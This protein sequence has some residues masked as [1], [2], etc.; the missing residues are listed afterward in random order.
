MASANQEWRRTTRILENLPDAVVACTRDGQILFVNALAEE[1]FGYSRDELV[2]QPVQMLW[3]ERV[4]D[5]YSHN[6]IVFFGSDEALRFSTEVWGLRRDGSEFAGE[7]SWGV[8]DTIAGRVLLAIGR[9][10]SRRLTAE[11]RLRAVAAINERALGGA[12]LSDLAIE[13][14]ELLRATLPL[15]GAEVRL[16]DGGVLASQGDVTGAQ[17]APGDRRR[18]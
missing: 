10:I 7:M 2:G 15:S 16:G 5:R 6:M 1:L 11:A 14:V 4:R 3:P 17:H 13:G 12:A 9:D 8:V 18:R